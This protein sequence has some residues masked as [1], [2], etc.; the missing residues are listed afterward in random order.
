M[1]INTVEP[2]KQYL[3]EEVTD[4][5]DAEVTSTAV[6]VPW[7][8]YLASQK[9]RILTRALTTSIASC[10]AYI[11]WDKE[12]LNFFFGHVSS[13]GEACS[14]V[15]L[16]KELTNEEYS[17]TAFFICVTG[18]RPKDTTAA[19]INHIIENLNQP[20]RL[21]NTDTGGVVIDIALETVKKTTGPVGQM[22]AVSK[23]DKNNALF[24]DKKL[25]LI[26]IKVENR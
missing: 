7:G 8:F 11:F 26:G 19:R 22:K 20:H 17:E 23:S 25:P 4:I 2:S 3:K 14:V 5:P 24:K 18:K 13:D 1:N 21:F 10:I 6:D 15:S 9:K 16:V 12:K